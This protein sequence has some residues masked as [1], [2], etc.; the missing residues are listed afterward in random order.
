MRYCNFVLDFLF[1]KIKNVMPQNVKN[2]SKQ[3]PHALVIRKMADFCV[4]EL[5][6]R[7]VA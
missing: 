3:L 6:Y 7:S 1:K 5:M 2:C 4:N